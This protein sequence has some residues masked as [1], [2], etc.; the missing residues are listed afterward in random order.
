MGLASI[1]RVTFKISLLYLGLF[2]FTCYLESFRQATAWVGIFHESLSVNEKEEEITKL[3]RH[4][5]AKL[6][7]KRGVFRTL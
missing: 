5:N 3:E 7:L 4:T 2:L 6:S 1:I